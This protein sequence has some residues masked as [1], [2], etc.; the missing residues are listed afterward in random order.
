MR[1]RSISA[2]SR[3][4][5]LKLAILAAD[6]V[7]SAIVLLHIR[8]LGSAFSDDL[9]FFWV[10]ILIMG[11]ITISGALLFG[12]SFPLS[13]V[14]VLS[15][16]LH[17][18]RPVAEPDNMAWSFDA[19]FHFQLLQHLSLTGHWDIGFGTWAAYAYSFYP[20]SDVFWSMV[21]ATTSF[22][23]VPLIKF[24]P[25]ILSSIVLIPLYILVSRILNLGNRV[26]H[27]AVLMFALN[28]LFNAK[29]DGIG[30]EPYAIIF[31]PIVL[32]YSMLGQDRKRPNTGRRAMLVI[33]FLGSLAIALSHHFTAYM[34]ALA[35]TLPCL[36]IYALTRTLIV[37]M[38]A[39]FLSLILPL[40]WLV[41][42]AE[43][44]LQGHLF[45]MLHLLQAA[46][47]VLWQVGYAPQYFS[48]YYASPFQ[49]SV[50]IARNYLLAGLMAVGVLFVLARLGFRLQELRHPSS[51]KRLTKLNPVVTYMMVS[52]V[53]FGGITFFSFFG[54]TGYGKTVVPD[55]MY[56]PMNFAFYFIAPFVGAGIAG[57]LA[58][59]QALSVAIFRAFSSRS[60]YVLE[61]LFCFL[62]IAI[63][64][65]SCIFQAHPRWV[66]DSTYNS[67]KYDEASVDPQQQWSH[68]FWVARSVMSHDMTTFSGSESSM[69]YVLG[70]GNQR[71]W[72]ENLS[73]SAAI[74]LADVWHTV[75]YVFDR[76][77]LRLPSR[78]AEQLTLSDMDVLNRKFMKIF[79]DGTLSDY[80]LGYAA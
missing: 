20:L 51:L 64:L 58:Q 57:S 74:S 42:V 44:F 50:T 29:Y 21:Q 16:T 19:A 25:T 15:I 26:G 3:L 72:N 27:L 45:T 43:Y 60:K 34:L 33:V 55:I 68:S 48:E 4:P 24:C 1:V 12:D 77:N 30:Q 53:V 6:I 47:L 13:L 31:F 32:V 59:S 18:I 69:R 17:L 79:D 37:Q 56:R 46:E 11:F 73:I 61:F 35:I 71:S 70:Y 9:F 65:S 40:F 10:P 39:L 67:T 66:Y 23:I 75:Y 49:A 36:A 5:G 52:L 28:P 7:L 63:F 2:K 8:F 78:R 54:T 22:P 80:V 14:L 41:F 38:E 76:N 62:L